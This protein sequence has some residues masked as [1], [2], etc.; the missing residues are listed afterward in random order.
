M[1]LPPDLAD[2]RIELAGRLVLAEAGGDEVRTLRT[3]FGFTQ[4]WLADKVDLRRESLS[5]IESGHVNLS[6]SFVRAFVDVMALARAARDEKATAEARGRRPD[7]TRL[8]RLAT[9]LDLDEAV[10]DEVVEAAMTSYDR[11]RRDV[12]KGLGG[13]SS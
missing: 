2:Y 1:A 12:I 6:L 7:T 11:K 8:A 5:R 9:H 13:E 3:R 4:E 10:A